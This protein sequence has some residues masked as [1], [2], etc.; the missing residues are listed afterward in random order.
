MGNRLHELGEGFA[1][2]ANE[3]QISFMRK[4][5]YAVGGFAVLAIADPVVRN[6]ANHLKHNSLIP[7]KQEPDEQQEAD[8]PEE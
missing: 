6:M 5:A 7:P 1:R 8:Q 3:Q 4:A 2:G